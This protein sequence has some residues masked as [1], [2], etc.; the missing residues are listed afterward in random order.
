MINNEGLY[1]W[2]I[3][4]YNRLKILRFQQ[5]VHDIFC[6]ALLKIALLEILCNNYLENISYEVYKFLIILSIFLN[7]SFSSFSRTRGHFRSWDQ[8]QSSLEIICGLEMTLDHFL[9]DRIN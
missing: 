6:F 9:Q 2:M 5:I 4:K 8:L 1:K 7:P 3:H